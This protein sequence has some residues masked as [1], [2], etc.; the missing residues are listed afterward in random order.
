M[1]KRGQ[2]R[3]GGARQG[4]AR[5]G[6]GIMTG[7]LDLDDVL[8]EARP[9][10][11]HMEQCG[12]EVPPDATESEGHRAAVNLLQLILRHWAD[13]GQQ[14]YITISMGVRAG[15]GL[16]GVHATDTLPDLHSHGGSPVR[17]IPRRTWPMVADIDEMPSQM[18][19]L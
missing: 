9:W 11:W 19:L 1:A 7:W 13:T 16:I 14:E 2:A 8:I 18:S 15:D 5:Q 6:T 12:I 3:R 17:V 4:K 10:R